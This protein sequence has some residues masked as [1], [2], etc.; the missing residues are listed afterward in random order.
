[1]GKRTTRNYVAAVILTVAL[2][3]FYYVLGVTATPAQAD[4]PPLRTVHLAYGCELYTY[5]DT[6]NA[7]YVGHTAWLATVVCP[8]SAHAVLVTE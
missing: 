2:V 6:Y 4:T 3:L 1:M 7:G 5:K 8:D